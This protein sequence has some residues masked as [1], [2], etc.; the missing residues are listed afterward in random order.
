MNPLMVELVAYAPTQYF[1]CRSCEV[2]MNAA[3]MSNAQK[4]HDDSF[5]TSMPPEMM[6]EYRQFA[7]WVM[8]AAE[9]YGG[10]VIF[11]VVDAASLEGVWKSLRYGVRKYPALIIDGKGKVIGNDFKQAEQLIDRKLAT[12]TL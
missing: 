8:N 4:F 10:R 9:H 3:D 11:K 2:V 1:Q 7:D 5:Q 6:Q 12:Q